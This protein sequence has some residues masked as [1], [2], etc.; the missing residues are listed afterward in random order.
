MKPY[1]LYTFNGKGFYPIESID[2]KTK[3]A[4]FLDNLLKPHTFNFK[5]NSKN[6]AAI[7]LEFVESIDLKTHANFG[8]TK[9]EVE[10]IY[11]DYF[12]VELD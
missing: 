12:K 3:T 9:S 7:V 6:P 11:S 8:W 1:G 4:V 2:Y 10:E 5:T